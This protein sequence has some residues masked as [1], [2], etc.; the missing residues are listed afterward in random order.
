MPIIYNVSKFLHLNSGRRKCLWG[1]LPYTRRTRPS[2]G[3][4]WLITRSVKC[5]PRVRSCWRHLFLGRDADSFPASRRTANYCSFFCTN[6]TGSLRRNVLTT[7]SVCGNMGPLPTR[8]RNDVLGKFASSRFKN[9]TVVLKDWQR[10]FRENTDILLPWI[11][12]YIRLIIM[13]GPARRWRTA[14]RRRIE[15]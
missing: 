14:S 6:C 2:P 10:N 8:F 4:D 13:T 7:I 15:R 3:C 9:D 11:A 1:E 12:C 5:I